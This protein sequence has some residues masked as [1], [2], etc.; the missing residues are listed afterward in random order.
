ML[1]A[2]CVPGPSV[3]RLQ[4]L[5]RV[6]VSV[7]RPRASSIS[8]RGRRVESAGKSRPWRSSGGAAAWH[9]ACVARG[10]EAGMMGDCSRSALSSGPTAEPASILIV[11]GYGHRR[12]GLEASPCAEGLKVETAAEYLEAIRKIKDGRFALAIIDVDLAAS[13]N[14]E[15]TG[16]D[17]ARI[18]RA[19]HPGSTL[20]LVTAEWRPDL[21]IE[22]ARLPGC[23]LLEKPINPA[24][25]RAML[26]AHQAE[27]K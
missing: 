4:K 16:W 11:E 27:L 19:L 10:S 7:T 20:V 25:L 13:R 21:R 3:R 24:E 14:S 23:Q 15:L 26:R 6:R 12:E 1:D 17:L 5:H 8:P 9:P 2:T 18:F 22:A